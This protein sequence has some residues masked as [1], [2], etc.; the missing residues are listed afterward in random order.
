M[1]KTI[2]RKN[3]YQDSIN[4]M[5]LTRKINEFGGV[6]RS[7]IMMGTEANKNILKSSGLL[8]DEAQEASSNDMVIV[9]DAEDEGITE[10]IM[11][12]IESFFNDL[13]VKDRA[14]EAREAA[15]IDTAVQMLPEA[16]VALFSIPGEYAASEMKKAL[17]LGLNVFSFTDNISKQD[18]INLKKLAK[19]KGLL[20][21][22]PDCGT[23]AI[24][25]IPLAFTNV[26]NSG[27]IS[28][29]GA[30]GT[31]IQEVSCL[32]D[33]YGGGIIHA[34]GTGGRDLNEEVKGITMKDALIALNH[35][36]ETKVIALI[37]KP[38]AK[39]V[40]DE[41][42]ELLHGLDKPVVAVFLGEKP[43]NHEGEVYFAYTL[44]ECARMAVDLSK[45]G[46]VEKNYNE[47][48][49]NQTEIR[50]DENAGIKGLYSGGTLGAEAAM[51][52]AD[53]LG[54]SRKTPKEGYLLDEK[55]YQI[56]DL[57][58]DI[59]TVGRPHPM[60]DPDVRIEKI[61]ELAKADENSII[62]IDIVLGYGT[63]E[64]MVG[65]LIPA[66]R[67][68]KKRAEERGKQICFVSSIVGT[69]KDIQDYHQAAKRLRQEGVLVEE[70]NKK[71]V[72]RALK[73]KGIEY[74]EKDK[75]IIPADKKKTGL[76]PSKN[77]VKLLSEKP[78]I[79]NIG[80]KS[81]NKSIEDCG[82]QYI[83]VN[84]KPKAGGNRKLIQRIDFLSSM[85]KIK[86]ANLAVIEKMKDSQP[87]LTDVVLAK[88]VIER[89]H[90]K[91]I[92][93]AG[94]P[95]TYQEMTG[96]MQGSCIGAVLFEKWA[97]TEEEAVR[98]LESGEIEFCPCHH[99][100]AVGPMGGITTANMPVLVVENRLDKTV[101]Y[102]NVNEGIGK[103][104]RFGAYSKE[105]INRLEWMR[106][107]LCPALSKA[108][109]LKEGGINLSVLVAKAITM[110]DEFHQRNIAASQIFLKEMAPYLVIA[111]ISQEERYQ[112]IKFLADTEQF[113][114]NVMMATGKAIVDCARKIQEG[115]IVTTLARNGKDFGVRIAGMGDEWFTAPV[116]TPDGLYFTGYS[117]EDANKDIGDSA[118][119]ET[120]GVGGMAMIAAPGVTRFVGAG[121]FEEALKISDE[122]NEICIANNAN[123]SIPTWNFKGACL[124]IDAVKVVETGITPL[125]NTGIAHKK[126][127]IGQI[128]AGTVRAPL[129]CFEK[130]VMAYAEKLGFKE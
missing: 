93:H 20:M 72:L 68:A 83:W 47:L 67:E 26:I 36:S 87:F 11:G 121:G 48:P 25:G 5:M 4:L 24:S 90:E 15:S 102:C 118:I 69:D 109:K 8:T 10:K 124:G 37:S 7:Q 71:A 32:I 126:A 96:P 21:M 66:I 30:S 27:D 3:N 55:G 104:L 85:D 19:E 65:A 128:G 51:L 52:I 100:N 84:W 35:H 58:D 123:W 92:L 127:G 122:M 31:G 82:G 88:T 89:L 101:A 12:E 86:A 77:L 38:P 78:R 130:A 2:I 49:E 34:I 29:V 117:A 42:V 108:L 61:K 6:N 97:N 103:V 76:K 63:H 60:I 80:L 112:V 129:E 14:H 98:L 62:L 53:T 45:K 64:D 50:F 57:G 75:E 59:Y 41:I 115:T 110:G 33:K 99:V 119:T 16:N 39:E 95:I 116:N 113:F 114:L 73:L 111:D 54:M 13:Q 40:R 56:L 1:L 70:S 94:P 79:I 125:I 44:E 28:I 81:F 120:V 43:A 23:G 9:I 46:S 74:R 91:L 107:V 17:N 18:E 106:D 105:V 22:G